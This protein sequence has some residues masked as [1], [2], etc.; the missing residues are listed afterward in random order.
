MK[1]GKEVDTGNN[2]GPGET[3]TEIPARD[4]RARGL[5]R[6][7]TWTDSSLAEASERCARVSFNTILNKTEAR[8][9]RQPT[10]RAS[11]LPSLM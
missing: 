11:I 5:V 7:M 1:E 10:A 8:F 4:T 6:H 9:A 2:K 3:Y